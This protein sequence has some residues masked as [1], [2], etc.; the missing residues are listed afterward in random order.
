MSLNYSMFL[1]EIKTISGVINE[2]ITVFLVIAIAIGLLECFFGYKLFEFMVS[3]ICF[4]LVGGIGINIGQTYTSVFLILLLIFLVAGT[5]GAILAVKLYLIGVFIISFLFGCGIGVLINS[6]MQSENMLIVLI[7]GILVGIL[8]LFLI[9]HVLIIGTSISGGVAVGNAVAT[10]ANQEQL[11]A[12]IIGL[13]LSIIGI[14]IQYGMDRHRPKYLGKGPKQTITV[15]TTSDKENLVDQLRNEGDS[16]LKEAEPK[17]G[18]TSKIP[19]T[20]SEKV[21]EM[22]EA[23]NQVKK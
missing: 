2:N 19:K 6:T 20:A 22:N 4:V 11:V 9:K 5:I 21:A 15:P 16:L 8:G 18:N 3:I 10:I 14:L 13:V 17:R 1:E 12:I 23:V 7:V